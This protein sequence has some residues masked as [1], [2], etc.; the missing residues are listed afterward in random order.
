MVEVNFEP[1][2]GDPV[3]RGTAYPL[4]SATFRHEASFGLRFAPHSHKYRSTRREASADTS[5]NDKIN[6]EFGSLRE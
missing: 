5:Q 2:H 6:R 3:V 1:D 4:W